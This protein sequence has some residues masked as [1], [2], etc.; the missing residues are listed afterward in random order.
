MRGAAWAGAIVFLAA[1]LPAAWA[2]L[3]PP[4]LPPSG[5]GSALGLSAI[6]AAVGALVG[7]GRRRPMLLFATIALV[8]A[9]MVGWA[10][11]VRPIERTTEEMLTLGAMVVSAAA[12]AAVFGLIARRAEKDPHDSAALGFGS[13]GFA[14]ASGPMLAVGAGWADAS[15]VAGAIAISMLVACIGS[16]GRGSGRA[17]GSAALATAV[18]V[19]SI[20]IAGALSAELDWWIAP[21]AALAPL[22]WFVG[23]LP[24][25]RSR[26]RARLAGRVIALTAV[27]H[28]ATFAA[29]VRAPL[30]DYAEFVLGPTLPA[31]AEPP[32]SEG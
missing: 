12:C 31:S 17:S 18:F 10:W 21:I 24:M 15:F 20:W 3:A 25:L 32:Q 5:S 19:P 27:A 22:G 14:A 29:I 28:V 4:S 6:I 23:E 1:A 16:L 8:A 30:S 9:A 7:T 2:I 11:L 13:L 26:P